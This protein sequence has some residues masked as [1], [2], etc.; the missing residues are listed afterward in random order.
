MTRANLKFRINYSK[1]RVEGW[2]RLFFQ[3]EVA[4]SR[5]LECIDDVELSDRQIQL[6]GEVARWI[7]DYDSKPWL[8]IIGY[9]GNGKTT[10]LRAVGKLI[11]RLYGGG[12][13]FAENLNIVNARDYAD[14]DNV[15]LGGAKAQRTCRLLAIDDLG[16]EP[17]STNIFGNID[18]PMVDLFYHR[19]EA[20]KFTILSTNLL[21]EDLRE[22]YKGRVY[23]RLREMSEVITIDGVSHRGV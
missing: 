14:K 9:V 15:E 3:F 19:Y 17:L 4:R 16:T 21:P 22:R 6:I 18:T 12:G 7:T 11:E 13:Q 8:L 2:L 20:R 10:I 1:E 5:W 23:D